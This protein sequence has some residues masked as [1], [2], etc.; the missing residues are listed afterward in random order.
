MFFP[1]AGA[2]EVMH[3]QAKRVCNACPILQDCRDYALCV[4]V[5]G[6]WGGLTRKQRQ[7]VQSGRATAPERLRPL[8]LAP[9]RAALADLYA[10]LDARR[11]ELGMAWWKVANLLRVSVPDLYA[12]SLGVGSATLRRVAEAWLDAE[13]EAA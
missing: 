10:E 9:E 2:A 12:L 5:Y 13:S 1:A 11:E 3:E 6:V 8:E 4:D 7:A